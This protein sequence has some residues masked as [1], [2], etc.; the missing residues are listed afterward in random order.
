MVWLNYRDGC[1]VS[2]EAG[3]FESGIGDLIDG[4]HAFH[5]DSQGDSFSRPN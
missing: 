3:A 5:M 2:V 4:S 1:R